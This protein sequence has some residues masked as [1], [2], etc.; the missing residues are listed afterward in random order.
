MA[1]KKTNKTVIDTPE[2]LANA[3][4]GA[5]SFIKYNGVAM[6]EKAVLTALQDKDNYIRTLQSERSKL[7]NTIQFILDK[8]D[9]VNSM[10][11]FPKKIN[12]MWVIGNITKIIDLVKFII[13]AVK[14]LKA[15]NPKVK[16]I[17]I[18]VTNP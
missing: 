18:T 1:T 7:Q 4:A 13:E 14:E 3:V 9:G 15:L 16:P 5:T 2:A 6:S 17:N 8:L 11:E 12:F 10:I